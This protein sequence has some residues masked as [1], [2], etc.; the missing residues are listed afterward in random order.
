MFE[1]KETIYKK[2]DRE[3]WES[4]RKVLKEQGMRGVSAGHYPQDAVMAGG[5]GA[6]LDPRN[7]GEKGRADHDVYYIRVRQADVE[8]AKKVI[9]E[10]G[11][12]SE[13]KSS[14]ELMQDAAERAKLLRAQEQ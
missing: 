12:V 14:E 11:L 2:K 3:T 5:C 8:A 6:K 10:N 4:I 13:V 9:L 1:K 7:F